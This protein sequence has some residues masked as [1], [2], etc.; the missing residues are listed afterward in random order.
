MVSLPEYRLTP[1]EY[2][3]MERAAE[4][5]SE[6][7]DGVVMAMSGASWRHN[8]IVTAL[9]MGLGSRV[10]DGWFVLSNDMKVRVLN[11]TR[12]FYPDVAVVC[13]RP[14]FADDERDVLL[15]PLIVIEVLSETSELY[16]RSRKF[17]SYQEIASLQEYV[18]VSQE[19]ALVE[20]FRREADHWVYT[21]SDSLEA[22]VA[23][24]AVGCELPLREIYAQVDFTSS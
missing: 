18:L 16:D 22:A 3:R 14:Q 20:H 1:D 5:K 11:P 9:V 2:L 4:L 12:F 21:K 6:Y 13:D 10:G 24:P 17:L 15:N 7:D 23:L 19:S 8:L